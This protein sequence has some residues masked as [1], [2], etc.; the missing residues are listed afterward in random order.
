MSQVTDGTAQIPVNVK[1]HP[2]FMTRCRY[3]ILMGGGGSGKSVAMAQKMFVRLLT[4]PDNR[5]LVVRKERVKI[6]E[7][8]WTEFFKIVDQYDLRSEFEV[9]LSQLKITH[10]PSGNEILFIGMDDPEKVKS[11]SGITSI[12]IEEA[13]QLD[14]DDFNQL[15][16]RLRGRTKN[17]KQITCCLNPISSNHWIKR[18]FFDRQDP[19]VYTLRTT[20]LDNAYIDEEYKN[21]LE[22]RIAGNPQ[23]YRIYALGEW[24]DDDDTQLIQ[25]H[26]IHQLYTNEVEKSTEMFLSADV[27][28]WGSDKLVFC[29]WRGLDCIRIITVDKCSGKEIVTMMKNLMEVHRVPESNLAYDADGIG[30]WMEGTTGDFPLA[31]P[32]KATKSALNG[33]NFE[34]QKSQMYYKLAEMVNTNKIRISDGAYQREIEEELLSVRR[35][36]NTEKKLGI[37]KKKDVKKYLGGRSPD[38]S[39]A[40]AYRMIF[41]LKKQPRFGYSWISD[42]DDN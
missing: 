19:D 27:A 25:L 26:K 13:T 2:Y 7:S 40:L 42:S 33:E 15:D 11:I 6:L 37:I 41:E 18:T 31:T 39:D 12:F 10:R 8:V 4:E 28:L 3:A 35:S 17:L 38:F 32:I 36:I 30:S 5:F 34:H 14:E 29:V 22:K 23:L 9:N 20:Y 1:Y 16:L 24:G 21:L